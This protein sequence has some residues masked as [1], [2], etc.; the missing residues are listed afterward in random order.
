MPGRATLQHAVPNHWQP[1]FDRYDDRFNT[2]G[3]A[4]HV[5]WMPENVG[6]AAGHG[7]TSARRQARI[8]QLDGSASDG[9]G[10]GRPGAR[11]QSRPARSLWWRRAR[12][13]RPA[14]TRRPTP[15]RPPASASAPASPTSGRRTAGWPPS[16]TPITG[17][18]QE[19]SP[20]DGKPYIVQWF[21]RNRFEWHPENAAAVQ[22][23]ARPA[24]APGDGGARASRRSPPFASTAD[25]R[26][27]PET[28]HSLSGRFL[29]Y[30]QATGGLAALRLPDQRAVHRDQPD[31]RQ[32]LH[33]AILRARPLRVAPGEQ[34]ALRRAARPA[35][36][37]AVPELPGA[38]Q[39][40]S[41]GRRGFRR[42]ARLELDERRTRQPPGKDS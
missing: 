28:G 30:W 1:Q 27:V 38:R 10:A 35:R 34:A 18:R 5:L 33:R 7:A 21:E 6:P 25:R 26:Y 32:D 12:R 2:P 42:A 9:A 19:V 8:V 14:S 39:T 3:G 40:L 13:S 22:R 29:Q 15:V 17:E 11:S 24:G 41:V 37:P 20:T 31:R 23:A 16:A 36:S 4:V